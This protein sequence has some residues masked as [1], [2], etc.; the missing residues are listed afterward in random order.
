MSTSHRK[1]VAHGHGLQVVAGLGRQFVG[2]ELDHRVVELQF[3][4]VDGKS[5]CRSRE[6][7]A[8]RMHGVRH[9]SGLSVEPFLQHNLTMFQDHDAVQRNRIGTNGTSYRGVFE[10]IDSRHNLRR[11]LGPRQVD[12]H[13]FWFATRQHQ[14][15]H[16]E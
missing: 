9:L 5:Y 3:P 2:E 6:R 8:H 1:Q 12:D 4:F 13:F 7:L 10:R 15:R 11:S 16:G 14:C